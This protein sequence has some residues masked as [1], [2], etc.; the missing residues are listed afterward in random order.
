MIENNQVKIL[1]D[2]NIQN[3]QV[4]ETTIF[5]ITVVE[6]EIGKHLL[7]DVA[8][9]GDHNVK[10]ISMVKRYSGLKL[11]ECEMFRALLFQ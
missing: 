10:E 5:N 11:A 3:D 1:C 8:V 6:K 7:I 9:P 2:F 4:I